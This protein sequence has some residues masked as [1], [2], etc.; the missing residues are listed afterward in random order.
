MRGVVA[1]FAVL[2]QFQFAPAPAAAP[3][4]AGVVAIFVVSNGWHTEIVVPRAAL[5]EG[6][7]PEAADFP[8]AAYLGFGWG[9]AEYYPNPDPGIGLKL[10]AAL[11]PAPAVLHLT[12]L[13]IDPRQ[14][15]RQ[16]DMAPVAL[17]ADGLSRL[18]RYLDAS[19]ARGGNARA[20]SVA[21]GLYDVSLFYP[22]TGTF[23]APT[24]NCNTWTAGAL[25][26]AGLPIDPAGIVRAEDVM[27]RLR[28]P[29]PPAADSK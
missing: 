20:R 28:R 1:L 8:H 25:A 19:F 3:A 22:A 26:A 27:E 7:I 9:H 4:A 18:V 5:P 17:G 6:A 2:A 24:N 14:A 12:G 11:F 15:Y 13:E 23:S 16:I 29:A 21:P 10:K